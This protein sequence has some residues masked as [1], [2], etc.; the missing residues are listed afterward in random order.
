MKLLMLVFLILTMIV[1]CGNDK[2]TD[3]F[4]PIDVANLVGTWN[5][6]YS[7]TYNA[8]TDSA[9]IYEVE[10]QIL[11]ATD[12]TLNDILHKLVFVKHVISHHPCL[13]VKVF[14]KFSAVTGV[15]SQYHIHFFQYSDGP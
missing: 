8:G 3:P 5:G 11:F 7:L 12:N 13:D 9:R 1:S 14:Q 15:F 4:V 10:A 6:T 2:T